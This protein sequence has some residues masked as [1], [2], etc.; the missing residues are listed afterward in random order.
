M[1]LVSIQFSIY[2]FATGQ[3]PKLLATTGMVNF[4]GAS[5]T[6][7][8]FDHFLNKSIGLELMR[9]VK[10]EIETPEQ[11]RA[12]KLFAFGLWKECERAKVDLQSYNK[13]RCIFYFFGIYNKAKNCT[14]LVCGRHH[15]SR[16]FSSANTNEKK[17]F[18]AK[19]LHIS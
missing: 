9:N 6:A 17:K 3:S 18:I 4:G 13:T 1:Y 5:L 7:R 8:L 19:I 16:I 10:S 15:H 12:R 11:E 2:R 14:F